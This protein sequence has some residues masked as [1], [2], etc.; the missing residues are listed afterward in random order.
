MDETFARRRQS[1]ADDQRLPL[2]PSAK[3]AESAKPL[4]HLANAKLRQ[5]PETPAARAEEGG[6][7]EEE[8]EEEG[9]AEKTQLYVNTLPCI[10]QLEGRPFYS[11][12]G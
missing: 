11:N 10:E 7:E 6:K 5:L 1:L 2:P 3:A 8:E 9:N 12:F 4:L